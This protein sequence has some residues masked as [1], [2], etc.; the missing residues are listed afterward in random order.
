M[1]TEDEL[2]APAL[3]SIVEH[4][5]PWSKT[6]TRYERELAELQRS[7]TALHALL[8]CEGAVLHQKEELIQLLQILSKESDHRFLNSLQMIASMLSMQ[9]RTATNPE[10]A[11]QLTIAADRVIMIGAIHRRLHCLDGAQTVAFKPYLEE[12]CGDFAKMLGDED[13]GETTVRVDAIEAELPSAT[14]THLGFIVSELITNAAKHGKGQ[15]TV[16]LEANGDKAYALS[17]SNDGP[18]LP[19][20]FDPNKSKG[21]GMTIIRSLTAKI[22]GELR[23]GPGDQGQG[24]RF[25]VLFG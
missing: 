6:I 7:E 25:T 10:T 17:V 3:G 16:R 12:L 11:S 9:A 18:S 14:C 8:A 20:G 21:L 22:G 4:S 15:I 13:G 2:H 19:S 5:R 24:A 1:M 23:F